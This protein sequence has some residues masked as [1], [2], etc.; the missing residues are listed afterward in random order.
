MKGIPA[1]IAYCRIAESDS[2]DGL[3]SQHRA[4]ERFCKREEIADLCW[5]DEVSDGFR[6]PAQRPHLN[7]AIELAKALKVPLLV[8]EVKHLSGS[9]RIVSGL[10][11]ERHLKLIFTH[12]GPR[13]DDFTIHI[14]AAFANRQCGYDQESY[15]CD[16][17]LCNQL[18]PQSIKR[19]LETS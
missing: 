9:M 13:A 3:A 7:E 10:M 14:Y 11:K 16:C 12:L 8:N 18:E 15:E 6:C 1:A 2:R 5:F 19:M 4:I 17:R